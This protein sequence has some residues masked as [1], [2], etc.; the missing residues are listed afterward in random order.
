[1]LC[2]LTGPGLTHIQ[3]HLIYCTTW[4]KGKSLLAMQSRPLLL[5][6]FILSIPYHQ[7]PTEEN[8]E[9]KGKSLLTTQKYFILPIS[10]HQLPHGRGAEGTSA[11]PLLLQE[12]ETALYP[13]ITSKKRFLLLD[14]TWA[15]VNEQGSGKCTRTSIPSRLHTPCML[16]ICVGL[17]ST[18]N[19]T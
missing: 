12:P 14:F 7:L 5:E 19:N 8:T 16:S 6:Y 2:S 15:A 11:Q 18:L 1:M 10:Y 3:K 13:D 9:E 4:V 17:Y